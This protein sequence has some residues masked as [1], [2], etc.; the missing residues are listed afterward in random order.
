MR[1]REMQNGRGE[2][3]RDSRSGSVEVGITGEK[4]SLTSKTLAALESS[5]FFTLQRVKVNMR[6]ALSS[7]L[8]ESRLPCLFRDSV[9]HI[10]SCI[11]PEIILKSSL[12]AK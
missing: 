4:C 12:G 5:V 7:S 9:L 11:W 1:K 8:L 3:N 6:V 10:S 2:G